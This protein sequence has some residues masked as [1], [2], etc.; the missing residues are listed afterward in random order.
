[1]RRRRSRPA[2]RGR[3]LALRASD[4]LP[5]GAGPHAGGPPLV[6]RLFQASV[7]RSLTHWP[8]RRWLPLGDIDLAVQSLEMLQT[9]IGRCTEVSKLVRIGS[10]HRDVAQ[11]LCRFR[12]PRPKK[13]LNGA[14]T[15]KGDCASRPYG[16]GKGEGKRCSTRRAIVTTSFLTRD[17]LAR[18]QRDRYLLSKIDR[19]DLNA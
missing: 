8:T 4:A 2:V 1:M 17:A 14:R 19:D 3:C 16:A 9:R 18:V 7:A 15:P 11:D 6:G 13:L 12:E 5:I 10:A